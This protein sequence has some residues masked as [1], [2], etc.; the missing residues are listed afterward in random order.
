MDFGRLSGIATDYQDDSLPYSL[1]EHPTADSGWPDGEDYIGF[2][3]RVRE[4]CQR[5]SVQHSDDE[6]VLSVMH[7]G[8]VMA[9]RDIARGVSP[10]EKSYESSS[11]L[12][13]FIFE[14]KVDGFGGDGELVVNEVQSINED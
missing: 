7:Q 9:I 14:M 13:G 6:T 3:S 12:G 8:P 1:D 2:H 10:L 11:N 4:F 5:V